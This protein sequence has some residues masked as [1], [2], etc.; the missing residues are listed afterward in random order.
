MLY[1]FTLSA[2]AELGAH[3]LARRPP[4]GQPIL[5]LPGGRAALVRHK[6]QRDVRLHEAAQGAGWMFLKFRHV[7]KLAEQ[8][9]I[10]L[11]T[12]RNALGLDPLIEQESRQMMLL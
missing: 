9:S 1:T 4:R 11:A 10:D 8:P 3:L 2:T 5:V 7:R 6:L 12:F